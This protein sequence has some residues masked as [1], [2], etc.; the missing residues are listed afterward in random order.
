MLLIWFFLRLT[1]PSFKQQKSSWGARAR[2]CHSSPRHYLHQH[3]TLTLQQLHLHSLG[4]AALSLHLRLWERVSERWFLFI[5]APCRCVI[6]EP[7]MFLSESATDAVFLRN[8]STRYS[9]FLFSV[10]FPFW[11]PIS[12]IISTGPGSRVTTPNLKVFEKKMTAVNYSFLNV[13]S[14]CLVFMCP[15]SLFFLFSFVFLTDFRSSRTWITGTPRIW[16]TVT[17]RWQLYGF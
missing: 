4:F 5:K 17:V 6:R 15:L 9:R 2:R 3:L 11:F 10:T 16:A 12:L 8:F 1:C 13:L 7:A 14:E